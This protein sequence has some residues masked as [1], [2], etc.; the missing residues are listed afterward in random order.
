MKHILMVCLGNICRSPLAEGILNHKFKQIG[1]SSHVDSA[2]TA[3]YHVGE[4]P[5]ARSQDIA[6]KHGI[7]ISDQRAR[8]FRIEDFDHFDAIYVMDSYNYSDILAMARSKQ[9]VEKVHMIMNLLYPEGN[10]QVPDPYYGGKDG[11]LNVF[12]MLDSACDV[13]VNKI[14]S[15]NNVNK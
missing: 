10:K 8:R 15:Q 11:F 14:L 13:I 7:D 5:D 9:D 4:R 3:A 12:K 6:L 1:L 2:G